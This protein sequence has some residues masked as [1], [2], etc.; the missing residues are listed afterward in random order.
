MLRRIVT[1]AVILCPLP[2]FAQEQSSL[3]D[4]VQQRLAGEP[5]EAGR[6]EALM[7]EGMEAGLIDYGLYRGTLEPIPDAVEWTAPDTLEYRCESLEEVTGPAGQH[8]MQYTDTY[9]IGPMQAGVRRIRLNSTDAQGVSDMTVVADGKDAYPISYT[10]SGPNLRDESYLFGPDGSIHDTIADTTF[11]PDHP[12]SRFMK[13]AAQ[14]AMVMSRL[15]FEE[16]PRYRVGDELYTDAGD[17]MSGALTAFLAMSGVETKSQ[18]D[19]ADFILTGR[20]PESE[21]GHLVYQGTM[22]G[23]YEAGSIPPV[24]Y[25]MSLIQ[26][27]DA[28]AQSPIFMESVMDTIAVDGATSAVHTQRC[29]RSDDEE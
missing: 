13:I 19:H 4:L 9:T 28:N 10:F 24:G 18:V 14:G 15:W 3:A 17:L 11:S 7:A 26:I 8:M 6:I 16:R 12:M 25:R 2:L 27:V 1:F 21:G 5:V 20:L 22:L 29:A 23:H